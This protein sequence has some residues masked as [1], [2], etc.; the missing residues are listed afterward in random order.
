VEGAKKKKS[1]YLEMRPW[2]T[3]TSAHAHW[4]TK[5]NGR[6]TMMTSTSTSTP[7]P[8]SQCARSSEER[9]REPKRAATRSNTQTK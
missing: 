9:Q 7:L 6:A 4:L 1:D 2:H 5:L 8:A 3:H